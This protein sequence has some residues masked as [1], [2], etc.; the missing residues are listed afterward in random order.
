MA[1]KKTATEKVKGKPA[2]KPSVHT[3]QGDATLA[4]N[5]GGGQV[6]RVTHGG[7]TLY[8]VAT[9]RVRAAAAAFFHVGGTADSVS[10]LDIAAMSSEEKAALLA[11]LQA[12]M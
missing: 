1:K 8:V 3:T 4:V 11:E 2:V 10:K 5:G 12:S 6:F 7:S 9:N